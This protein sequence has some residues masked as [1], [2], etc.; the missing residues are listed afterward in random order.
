MRNARPIQQRGPRGG[1]QTTAKQTA[2]DQ[3]A[4]DGRAVDQSTGRAVA[5]AVLL[6]VAIPGHRAFGQTAPTVEVGGEREAEGISSP[7]GSAGRIARHVAV[8]A[9]DTLE[10][11]EAG[12]RGGR[13][14]AAY[15]VEQLETLGLEPAGDGG[16]Y[17]QRFGGMQNVL[18]LLRG[19]DPVLSEELVIVGAH[20]DHVGY[21]TRA[22]SYGPVGL[23]HNGADD[24][25]SG[26]AGLLEFARMLDRLPRPRRSIL[27]AFWDGEEKGLLGSRHFIQDRTPAVARL[28][29]VFCVNLDMIG[30]LRGD[31][32][33]VYGSRTAVGLR[34]AV[35]R[36]NSEP[37][38]AAGL[39]IAF[40]WD[41]EE[42]SDHHAFIAA[43]IPSLMFHTGLHDQYHRPSDDVEL[44]N[45]AGMEPVMRLVAG[46][47]L[48]VADD[49]APAP[50]FRPEA[51]RESNASRRRLEAIA[52]DPPAI[53]RGR[54]GLGVRSDAGEPAA[55]VVVRVSRDR[56]A[57]ASDLQ[58]GDRIIAVDGNPLE[59]QRDM[60]ERLRAAASRTV[61]DVERR[62][63]I[64]RRELREPPEF[65]REFTSP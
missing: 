36:I 21:G 55:P 11:R 15:I 33:I 37:D 4:A 39:E 32:L 62:G 57:G 14:A 65:V 64:L 61:L 63:R 23:I 44:V 56:P 35:A 8:L 29:P 5:L 49:P 34:T 17:A 58:P 26:V 46:F 22:N 27:I 40:D 1:I 47:T 53:E 45:F 3:T 7:A 42:D 31:R 6:V 13:A 30:R 43:G 18:A 12:S 60:L 52:A 9:D 2:A 41:I 38:R 10:G 50:A 16:G 28:A 24:N 25:A 48:A 19:A 59:G 51:R 54:W 20:Y